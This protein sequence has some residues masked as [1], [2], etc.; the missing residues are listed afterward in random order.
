V[1][2]LLCIAPALGERVA[3]MAGQGLVCAT[4]LRAAWEQAPVA[5]NAVTL[6][7]TERDSFG[8]PRVNLRWR[9]TALDRKTIETSI[10]L[11]NDL[12]LDSDIGRFRL[13]DWLN[14]GGDYPANDERASFHH[15]GGTRMYESPRYGVVDENCKV[16]GSDNLY[17]AGSS[18]FTKSGMN[19]PTL[20]IL[21][22]AL[23]LADHLKAAG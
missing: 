19:N 10:A 22:F 13:S 14:D 17:I 2:D 7:G 12:L 20:P 3:A 16:F 21:Q 8:I 15:M 6:S 4:M 9:K 23:H 5:E 11:F 18:I 1:K